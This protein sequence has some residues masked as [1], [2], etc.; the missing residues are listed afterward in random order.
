MALMMIST[1]LKLQPSLKGELKRLPD[2]YAGSSHRLSK[3]ELE[4][5]IYKDIVRNLPGHVP[6]DSGPGKVTIYG[7]PENI[8]GIVSFNINNIK[9][10]TWPRYFKK[11]DPSV[12]GAVFTLQYYQ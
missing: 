4:C 9:P 11:L 8:Y 3:K 12:S 6:G 2:S 1:S 7:S 5:P 10:M